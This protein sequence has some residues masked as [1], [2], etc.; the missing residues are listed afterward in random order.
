MVVPLAVRD[1][2]S[3]RLKICARTRRSTQRPR[4]P[5]RRTPWSSAISACSAFNRC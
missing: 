3:V 4:S 5:Q 1:T 2:V